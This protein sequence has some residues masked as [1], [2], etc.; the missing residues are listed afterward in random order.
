MSCA[1]GGGL[2]LGQIAAGLGIRYIPRMKL[3]MTVAAVVMVTFVAAL[4]SV[5]EYS[6]TR[7]VVFLIIGTAA[8]GY[9]EN[10]TLSS[11][12]LVWEPEDIGLV[13]GV[14]GS[15]RTACSSVAT[16]LYL[17]I[18]SNQFAKHLPRYVTSAAT[19]AGLPTS[20]LED[21]FAGITAGSFSKVEGITPAIEEAVGHA[22]KRAYSMSFR[23]VFLCTL[24]FG[25]I[26][27][28]A[29]IISPNVEDY[30]TDDVA[31]RLQGKAVAAAPSSQ[32]MTEKDTN[33]AE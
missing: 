1:V 27:L 20:S 14:L 19:E 21:L 12:A 11:M 25:A 24:P 3:Q 16:S 26:I 33:A 9:I 6:R 5:D 13:A 17:S 23:T 4:A 22:V 32:V 30:L 28:V 7:T 29:A 15:I 18:L 2:L 31:R 10:L 8:A